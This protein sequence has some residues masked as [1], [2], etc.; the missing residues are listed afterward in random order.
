MVKT[1]SNLSQRSRK[2]SLQVF[3]DRKL[4][5]GAQHKRILPLSCMSAVSRD[6]KWIDVDQE[7]AS[8]V[9]IHEDMLIR[10]NESGLQGL[11]FRLLKDRPNL[12]QHYE[13]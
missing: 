8:T 3:F 9:D 7:G 11:A 5:I 12:V 13:R 6:Q 1:Q 2:L 4:G 10:G